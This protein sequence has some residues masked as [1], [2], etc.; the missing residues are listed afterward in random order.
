MPPIL[1]TRACAAL[2]LLLLLPGCSTLDEWL[3]AAEDPPLEGERYS[4]LKEAQAPE[5]SEALAAR[6]MALPP[7][8][9]NR[10]WS[11]RGGNAMNYGTHLAGPSLVERVLEV[12]DSAEAGDGTGW[13]TNLTIPPVVWEDTVFA[14]DAGGVV[15]AYR[16]EG[17]E[18]LWEHVIDEEDDD[19]FPG[20][21]IAAAGEAVFAVT[22]RGALVALG[23]K[24]GKLLWKRNLAMPVRVA[25]RVAANKLFLTTVDNQL[26][27][28]N[29]AD[30]SIAWKHQGIQEVAGVQS[31]PMVAVHDGMVIVPYSSGELYALD[32]ETGNE[33]WKDMMFL[34]KPTAGRNRLS[35]MV[36]SPIVA[37]GRVYV[38]S[39]AGLLV[40]LDIRNGARQ[41]EEELPGI[42]DMWLAGGYLYV[43]TMDRQEISLYA[44]DGR[45][46]WVTKLPGHGE[47]DAD[48]MWAGSALVS[49]QLLVFGAHGEF[50][51]LL[52][53]DGVQ[54]QK[55]D[56]PDGIFHMPSVAQGELFAVSRDATLYRMK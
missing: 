33:R 18:K 7:A 47:K 22:G 9:E 4:V 2:A 38:G 49:G 46:R 53:D 32:A 13:E 21:G 44:E 27:A 26:F 37:G 29:A 24:D 6:P 10:Y 41:W 45:V 5:V 36:A 34:G 28:I 48:D 39:Q 3:G 17:L 31:A 51:R 8:N 30:G 25:P 19:A 20:G 1:K 50:L 55:Y 16:R 14:M 40:A 35:D 54:I 12:E 23:A 56:W 52:P 11:Q 15:A 43:T 42:Q